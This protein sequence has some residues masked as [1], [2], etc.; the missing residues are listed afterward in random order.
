MEGKTLEELNAEY[1][2]D[3]ANGDYTPFDSGIPIESTV[4]ECP[5]STQTVWQT[6]FDAVSTFEKCRSESAWCENRRATRCELNHLATHEII[7]TNDA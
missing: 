5:V 4:S 3:V 6:A 7:D 1:A 2:A